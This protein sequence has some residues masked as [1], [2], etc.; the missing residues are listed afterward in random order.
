[1]SRC[2][3]GFDW[4]V[5]DVFCVT[6]GSFSFKANAFSCF[7]FTGLNFNE[8]SCYVLM[9]GHMLCPD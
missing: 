9:N 7:P 3:S 4:T 6:S 5:H 8:G 2:P 1:M